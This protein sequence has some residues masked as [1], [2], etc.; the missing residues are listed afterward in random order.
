MHTDHGHINKKN[1]DDCILNTFVYY[2][3]FDK[4][5]ESWLMTEN[6]ENQTNTDIKAS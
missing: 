5:E 3:L 1:I 2:Y 6:D 4:S